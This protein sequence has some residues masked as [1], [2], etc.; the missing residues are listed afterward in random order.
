V[1]RAVAAR[2]ASGARR[3]GRRPEALPRHYNAAG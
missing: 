1:I 2:R 3:A